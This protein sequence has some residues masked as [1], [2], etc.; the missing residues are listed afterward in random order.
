MFDTGTPQMTRVTG[1]VWSVVNV[2]LALY[3]G[4]AGYQMHLTDPNGN[5]QVSDVSGRGG[6][7][8]TCSDC[9]DN[10][11]MNMKIEKRPY[12]P[13]VYHVVLMQGDKQVAPEV[14]FTL[15]ASPQQYVH[16]NFVPWH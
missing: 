8:S 14:E 4:Q 11:T 13:G 3:E 7:D 2:N 10:Q 15:A 1:M 6:T 9:G 16:I 5:E 12:V